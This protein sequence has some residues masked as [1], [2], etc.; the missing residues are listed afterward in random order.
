MLRIHNYLVWKFSEDNGVDHF[1]VYV[2]DDKN[3]DNSFCNKKMPKSFRH[4]S[5]LY[6]KLLDADYIDTENTDFTY[7]DEFDN[8]EAALVAGLLKNKHEDSLIGDITIDG[9]VLTVYHTEIMTDSNTAPE[10]F[11]HDVC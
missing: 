11:N 7:I 9:K 8:D 2:V 3:D 5:S 1:G 10:S 4:Q 6:Q